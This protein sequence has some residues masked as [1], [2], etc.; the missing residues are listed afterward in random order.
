M[1]TALH[2]LAAVLDALRLPYYVGG[3][4]ASSIHG[5]MRATADIDVVARLQRGDGRRL[6]ASLAE[7]CHGD[8]ESAENAIRE[9]RPFNLIHFQTML[10]FDFFPE[11]A[12]PLS[13]AAMER[14]RSLTTG[15]RVAT[16][17][18][19]LLAKLRWYRDGGQVSDRQWGDVLGVLRAQGDSLDRHYLGGMADALGLQALLARAMLD[20]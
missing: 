2:A 7:D 9:G 18:D 10:K 17:E 20:A 12:D 15:V 1:M 6:V 3:S 19:I 11:G 16:P 4:I 5:V 14:A 13:Q 8:A